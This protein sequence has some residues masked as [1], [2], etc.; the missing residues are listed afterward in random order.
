KSAFIE[1]N[2]AALA[3][4]TKAARGL[5]AV[6]GVVD[7]RQDLFNAAAV[8]HDGALAGVYHKQYL[9]NYGVFDE[10]RY[11]QAG[12]EASVFSFGQTCVAVN[13][14][15][16][17]WYPTGPTT[18][19]A[20]AGAELIVTINGSPYHAGTARSGLPPLPARSAPP[21]PVPAQMAEPLPRVGEVF[22][23][24]V[25][26]T[27]DYVRKNGFKRVV[28]GLSGGIDSALVAAVAAEGL[29]RENV[30]GV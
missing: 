12:R 20:L 13:V 11:F 3:E 30:T 10:N 19:Q 18:P 17:L 1:A 16:D 4:V 29:G 2:L 6:V 27:R 26:G 14:C 25:L 7:K 21:P 9:P 5:T 23:A 8:I 15:E 28:I 24:L 22:Q